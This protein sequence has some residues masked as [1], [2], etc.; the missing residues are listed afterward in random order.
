MPYRPCLLVLLV[1]LGG[2]AC[3]GGRPK[4]LTIQ[5]GEI[6]F[7]AVV[8]GEVAERTLTLANTGSRPIL[9]TDLVPNC[10]CFEVSPFRRTLEPGDTREVRIR[11]LS[12]RV[13]ATRLRGKK[14]D[15]MSDDANAARTEIPIQA[16]PFRPFTVSPP[17]LDLTGL[18]AEAAA[19]RRTIRVRAG[20][21]SK[22]EVG[23]PQVSPPDVL[24]VDV[25]P[26]EDGADVHVRARFPEGGLSAPL[27]GWIALPLDVVLPDGRQRRMQGTVRVVGGTP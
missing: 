23:T 16:M 3:G 18:D 9:V 25:A 5:P 4:G 15:V 11:F 22:V 10:V 1:L 19:R 26:V 17:S 12:E 7:G 24:E 20:E 13:P 8:H 2:T 21:G 14:L 6:D 27:R